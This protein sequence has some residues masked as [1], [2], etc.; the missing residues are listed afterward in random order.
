MPVHVRCPNSEC[1]KSL[2]CPDEHAGKVVQCPACGMQMQVPA[3]APESTGPQT[4][5]DYQLVRKIGQGGMGAVYEALQV[6]L[7]R[8]VALKILPAKSTQDRGFLERF[9]REAQA[10]AALNHPNIIQVYDIAEDQ[11]HH[12][13]AMELVDGENLMERLKRGGA[14][15]SEEAL[16][17]IEQV[18]VG[19]Q[20]AH[21]RS[22]IHRDIKPDNIMLSRD[23]QVKLADLGLAKSTEDDKGITQTGAGLGTPYYM[24]PEQAEDARNVDHRADI[25]ALGIT[26]LNLVT[27]KRPFDGDSAYSII[28]QHRERE[29]PAAQE[30]GASISRGLEAVIHKMAAKDV[31]QRYQDYDSL[32]SDLGKVRSGQPPEAIAEKLRDLPTTPAISSHRTA[33]ARVA[34]EKPEG[35]GK[36]WAAMAV[37]AVVLV[38]G[39]GVFLAMQS[40]L[41]SPQPRASATTSPA[42][43][44]ARPSAR[45]GSPGEGTARTEDLAALQAA[46]ESYARE[47][48][49][50][51]AEIIGKFRE[52]KSRGRGTVHGMEAT[53]RVKAWQEKWDE[54]AR[55][56]LSKRRLSAQEHLAAGQFAEA[57]KLWQEFPANLETESAKRR[58]AEETV[59]VWEELKG[60]AQRLDAE[61]EPL[62]A[63]EPSEL[64]PGDLKALAALKAKAENPPEGLPDEATE[65]LVSLVGKID[66]SLEGHQESHAAERAEAFNT[67]WRHYERLMKARKFEPVEALLKRSKEAHEGEAMTRLAAD[68]QIVKE[69]LARTESNL[70][71]LMGRN[72]RVGGISMK[73]SEVKDGRMYVDRGG[74]QMA[75]GPEQLDSQTLLSLALSSDDGPGTILKQKALFMF[76][77]GESSDAVKALKEAAESGVDLSWYQARLAP[78]LVTSTTPSEAEAKLPGPKPEPAAPPK[79]KPKRGRFKPGLVGRTKISGKPVD[80]VWICEHG[81]TFRHD[82]L[83]KVVTARL[84]SMP[85]GGL[86]VVFQGG[87]HLKRGMKVQIRHVGGSSTGGVHSL[88]IDGKVVS[89]VG[90]DRSKNHVSEQ[91]LARGKHTIRWV[92]TG[93]L[94]G[95]SFV[96]FENPRTGDLLPLY[97]TK[98]DLDSLKEC[99]V[100]RDI[101]RV[102]SEK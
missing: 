33:R 16:E 7:N 6:R 31:S 43:A 42:R 45:A 75:L 97:F 64:S 79:E 77:Y 2:Q 37:A 61:A 27:G 21:Q 102:T 85:R 56:E 25:Y 67:F 81:Q 29:L 20:F 35:K 58:V 51:F 15:P 83:A 22:I 36:S 44:R 23:G 24:A 54:A 74:A 76:Y 28:I 98:E 59:R 80:I 57:E 11:G 66:D 90:D 95:N 8:T 72:I 34:T 10:A 68:T 46:A 39:I 53:D 13:F 71:R 91:G 14:I 17:I 88:S 82:E 18:A 96:K 49:D 94:F 12:F 60:V 4:L 87:L 55:A 26:M 9:Y 92:L 69:L 78:V 47:H 65:A 32:L 38:A 48:P 19:L 89:Q 52:V 93:G 86:S 73:V 63:K 1:G 70:P 40:M 101:I 99:P 100:K 41:R 62:L 30:L 50:E 84:R 5:G 3:A